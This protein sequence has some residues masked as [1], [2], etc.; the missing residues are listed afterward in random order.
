[1]SVAG[2][3]QVSFGPFLLSVRERTLSTADGPVALPS[4]AFD[5]LWALIES[6][7]TI[8]SKD[9]L[10]RRVWS[11]VVV[12]ENNLHVQIAATRRALGEHSCYIKT[13]PGRGYSFI[14]DVV[15]RE[16]AGAPPVRAAEEPPS[17]LPAEMTAL[18]GRVTEFA[19]TQ[20]LL[21][22]ARLVTLV[23]PGGVG[24]TR[25]ALAV[26]NAV[27]AGFAG[28]SWLVE[29]GAVAAG[30]QVPEA[31]AASLRIEELPGKSLLEST[32]AALRQRG[33]MLLVLDGCEHVAAAV[34][35]LAATLLQRC[36]DLALL[37]T[38]QAPLGID[39]EHTRR[40]APL[41]VPD[42][43]VATA[44]TAMCYDAVRL[45]AA[46][47]AAADERFSLTDATVASV[48]KICRS[49]DGMPLAIE[50][51]AARV[52]LLGL[53]PVR[54]RLANRLALLGDDLGGAGR[55]RTLRAAIEW[56]SNLLPDADR[57][58]L[59]RL[60]VFAGG[61]TLAAA[62]EVA[63]GD[64][65]TETDIVQGVGN[66]VRRSLLTSG[67]DVMRPRHRMLEAM[68]EFALSALA[69]DDAAMARR[70]ALYFCRIAD[71]ADAA[72]ET[73][74][75][76]EWMAPF[77]PELENFRAALAWALSPAGDG[78]LA[79]RLAAATARI[80]FEG[81]HLSEG[82]GWLTQAL[83]RA[84]EQ[85]PEPGVMIRLQRGLAELSMDG[86]PA[87]ACAAAQAAV[88]LAEP[89]GGAMEGVCQRML[90]AALYL[91]GRYDEAEVA[92]LRAIKL[93]QG[94][95]H[96]R[97]LAKALSDIGIL[98]GVQRDYGAARRYNR[99]AQVLLKSIGDDRGAAIC[100]QYAAEFEFAAGET[101]EAIALAEESVALLR[102]LNSRFHLEIG[103]GNLAAYRLAAD[104]TAG[105]RDAAAEALVIAYEIED[106]PG[107]VIA[108]E[109][110]A[111]AAVLLGAPE[112]AARLHGYVEA[113]HTALG[114]ERQETEQAIGQRL[115]E[116]LRAAL[117]PGRL[118][119][120]AEEGRLLPMKAA[121]SLALTMG[122]HGARRQ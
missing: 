11:N 17:N 46:R 29:F 44:A 64:G 41:D 75:A 73:A 57:Q 82:R 77:G 104:D 33:R 94:T 2:Q 63:A 32:A 30:G 116:A 93:L 114:L 43:S 67:P 45:F 108:I 37:C 23:G 56:S 5:V 21:D 76:G 9:D 47:A 10:M 66:L 42:D 60:A 115:A 78:A 3:E 118:T 71:E 86:A 51:A 70:H 54:L 22:Q 53:E 119:N 4:R 110:I 79:A 12:E 85:T 65:F 27:A 25:L 16:R 81:G 59:R 62:Q 113:A 58:I 122:S 38:S 92:A 90:A 15:P 14:G 74:D 72:W 55:Q 100:L 111:L 52:P 101:A 40:I 84:R 69:G 6:R 83:S 120:L 20:S 96:T 80:W 102:G 31:L 18:V 48:I 1:M 89:Q 68:R 103:L 35:E 26:A 61:F 39:G 107:V 8:V 106:H 117:P 49:L 34:A 28:G 88:A 91:L 105:G 24:K 121:R 7:D 98:R 99:E 95:D 13:I 112:S 36:P 19:A 87:A 109:H 50:L 97:S